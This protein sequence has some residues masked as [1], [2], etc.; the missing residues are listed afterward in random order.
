MSEALCLRLLS[1]FIYSNT[2]CS[3]FQ[4]FAGY[5]SAGDAKP[6][7]SSNKSTHLP[8]LAENSTSKPLFSILTDG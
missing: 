2:I 3:L 6:N 5:Q 7:R 1:M 8:R 4:Q